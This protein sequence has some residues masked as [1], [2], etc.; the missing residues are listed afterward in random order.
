MPTRGT[1]TILAWGGRRG[2]NGGTVKGTRAMATTR[3]NIARQKRA[4]RK[5]WRG[6][7]TDPGY[8][9][10]FMSN[11]TE[12]GVSE[13]KAVG[14]DKILASGVEVRVLSCRVEGVMDCLQV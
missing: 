9:I 11:E 4:R 14:Y 7:E 10:M 12:V 2:G 6:R 1:S 3:M 5:N 8:D 13:V